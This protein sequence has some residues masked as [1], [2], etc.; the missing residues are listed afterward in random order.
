M[1]GQIGTGLAH[2]DFAG[3]MLMM[4]EWWVGAVYRMPDLSNRRRLPFSRA[5]D[6]GA[7]P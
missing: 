5:D 2:P 6:Y 3:A 1:A 4:S 7:A